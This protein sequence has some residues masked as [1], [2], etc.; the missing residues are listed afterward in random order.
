MRIYLLLAV[1]AATV[2]SYLVLLHFRIPFGIALLIAMA[3]MWG[4]V[5]WVR[6]NY[7]ADENSSGTTGED[8]SEKEEK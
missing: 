8:A 2:I 3:I 4:G 5:K 7:P 6:T 1:L